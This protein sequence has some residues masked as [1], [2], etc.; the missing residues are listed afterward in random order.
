VSTAGPRSWLALTFD[1]LGEAADLERGTWPQDAPLGRHPS[2]TEALPRLLD[3]LDA[4]GLRATFFLEAINC[5]LYPGALLEIAGHGHELGL[6]GW[7]HEAWTE[8]SGERERTIVRDGRAAF[9]QLGVPV[10]GFRPP[11]GGLNPGSPALLHE[12]GIR[13]CSPEGA[14]FGVVDRLAYVP[15]DWDLVDA[16]HLM[17]DFKA[18][19][20][21]RG[22]PSEPLGAAAVERRLL[23]GLG[24]GGRQTLIMHPFLMLDPDWWSSV[25]AVLARVARLERSGDLWVGP[26]GSLAERLRAQRP[27]ARG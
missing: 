22:D 8:L 18:L 19:R 11:G 17:G 27:R 20:L 21:A 23:E 26:G 13:W 1:N 25:R 9:A 16:Y 5:E 4:H 3:E 10:A 15:F 14:E 12:N 7:R 24:R 2:V 6:H